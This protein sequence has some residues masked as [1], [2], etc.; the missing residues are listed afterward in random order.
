MHKVIENIVIKTKKAYKQ[1]VIIDNE[2]LQDLLLEILTDIKQLEITEEEKEKMTAKEDIGNKKPRYKYEEV[3]DIT[4]VIV[5]LGK[6][7][8][9]LEVAKREILDISERYPVHNLVQY[10]KH[11]KDRFNGIG[12]YGMAIPANWAKALLEV[13][14]NDPMVIKALREQQRLYLEK[15]GTNN[16][17]LEELLNGLEK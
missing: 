9:P 17:T 14:G 3:K 5:K 1:S 2:E 6:D 10:N 4:E 7:L 13:T 8:I 12:T 15:D 11:M 16:R